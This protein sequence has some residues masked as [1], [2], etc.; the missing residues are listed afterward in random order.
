MAPSISAE[1]K[2]LLT[3]FS[4]YVSSRGPAH[5]NV[6]ERS[7]SASR[8]FLRAGPIVIAFRFQ[9][10]SCLARLNTSRNIGRVSLP[11]LVFCKRG[12]IAG[13]R[14]QSAGQRVLGSV[15]KRV[16]CADQF[17]ALALLMGQQ[18]VECDPAQ[19]NHDAKIL[20]QRHLV[21]HPR[22]AIAQFLGGGF[23]P[24]RS[25][26]ATDVIQRSVSFMPS[27]RELAR[28]SEAKPASCSTG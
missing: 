13:D 2:N 23:V 10:A 7:G 22:S 21:I 25:A 4:S 3:L 11:V 6:S 5:T 18:A 26:A 9:P 28:G 27:S 19:A 16:I 17:C 20:E 8:S 24:R 12:M 15:R 1:I 14:G